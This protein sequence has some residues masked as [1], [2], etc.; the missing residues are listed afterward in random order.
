MLG[1]SYANA[2]QSD[3]TLYLWRC[4]G[5]G[6]PLWSHALGVNT[7][8]PRALISQDGQ[9]V[10]VTYVRMIAQGSRTVAERSL[11]MINGGGQVLWEKGG[12]WL[13]PTLVAMAS[14]GQ[15]VTVSDGAKML[16]NLNASGRVTSTY[17]FKGTAAIRQTMSSPDGRFV[18]VYTSDGWLHL[19]QIG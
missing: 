8:F 18:L 16:Y 2:R 3:G 5:D 9:T 6:T 10:A 17:P 11:M 7:F 14:D 13:S 19:L 4:D 15:R 1:L 12:L